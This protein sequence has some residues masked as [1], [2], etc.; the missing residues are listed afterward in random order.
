MGCLSEIHG[1]ILDGLT[2]MSLALCDKRN[3]K[4]LLLIK[5]GDDIEKISAA[6]CDD[7]SK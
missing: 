3:T 1:V 2:K 7:E 5:M 4:T 6:M